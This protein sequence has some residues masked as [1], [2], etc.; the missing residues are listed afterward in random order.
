MNTLEYLR[1]VKV[2]LGIE[3]DYALAT[4]LGITRSAVSKLQLGKGVFGDDVALTVAQILDVHPLVVIAQANAERA[5]TPE[6]RA[7]WMDVVQG[8]L[9]LLPHAKTARR[10]ALPR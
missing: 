5:N 1:A 9:T 2:R 7:R 10:L 3:S 6:V 8:F 4:R